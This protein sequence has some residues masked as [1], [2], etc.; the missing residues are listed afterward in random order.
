MVRHRDD[1]PMKS[2]ESSLPGRSRI[3]RLPAGPWG[4]SVFVAGLLVL[5]VAVYFQ[6]PMW[7][8]V[9]GMRPVAAGGGEYMIALFLGA[10][11]MMLAG[12]ILGVG[13]CYP[14][15]RS[16]AGLETLLVTAI[17]I[18]AWLVMFVVQSF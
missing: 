15:C 1:V 9:L 8:V 13:S 12:V 2:T 3:P 14:R 10:P 5:W 7:L 18:L 6:I 4:W 11:L 17:L 16:W